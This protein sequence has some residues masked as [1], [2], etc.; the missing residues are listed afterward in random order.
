MPTRE[1]ESLVGSA[2]RTNSSPRCKEWSAQ[3]TLPITR[4][5]ALAAG[6]GGLGCLWSDW[7]LAAATTALA[8]P[9]ARSVILI[10]NC[11]GPSHLDLWDP[12]PAAPDNIRGPFRT[13]QTNVPGIQVTELL[14]R[15][16][17]RADKLAI[18]RTLHHEHGQHN[19]GMYWSIVGRPYRIDSTLINPSRADLPSVGTLVGWLAKRDGYTKPLPPY[20]ITPRPHC[21]SFQ[22]ITP[23]QYGACLGP[24]HD[25]FVLNADP[26]DKNFEVRGLSLAHGLS[27]ERINARRELLGELERR[28]RP[29][30]TAAARDIDLNQ[31]KALSLL[32]SDRA[33]AAF[34]L[35]REPEAVRERYGR[36]TWGQSHLLAR[37]LV[38]AGVPFVT[39]VN[40]PS[41]TWDTHTNNF[42]QMRDRLV[43]PM[44]QAYAALLDDLDERGLLDETLVVWMG[45][46][47]RTPA[48]NKDAGRDH[49]PQCYSM[50]LAGGGVRGGQVV[51]QS[52][53]HGAHPEHR[54]LT[55]A[56][57][58]AT[59]F[60]ALGYDARRITYHTTDGRP[61]VASE[62]EVVREVLS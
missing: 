17:Q 41:I 8:R 51:G 33:A 43:P 11:G 60:A 18:L 27:R 54:P 21:D 56:D 34:D 52:D 25:P 39:T 32:A 49:W 45:D 20:V 4:R 24:E 57:V 35:A 2:V 9:K 12:K 5:Q 19:A 46:F 44:E 59:I 22:Y 26:N 16:A 23:G 14:P 31:A 48:I 61:M 36:H 40:G 30:R 3:R 28:G 42:K 47:G 55:P 37:R 62:G 15:I 6:L 50:V 53:A 1:D 38:E 58:H 10:F 7:Q 13:I 29:V